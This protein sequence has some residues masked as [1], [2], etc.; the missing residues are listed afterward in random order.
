MARAL[1]SVWLRRSKKMNLKIL[2]PYKVFANIKNVGNIVAETSEGSYGFLPQRMDCVAV[3]VPG[4]FMYETDKVH[5]LAVDEGLFV[6][7]GSQVLVSVRNAVGGVELG[8][9]AA[10]VKNEFKNA[11][12][13]QEKVRQ[14]ASKLEGGFMSRLRKFQEP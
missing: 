10:M 7:T 11:D 14:I 4:I 5:Y 1:Q 3:L 13:N 8:K 12:E 9:L 6:K 2:L